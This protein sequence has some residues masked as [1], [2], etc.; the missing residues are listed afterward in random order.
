MNKLLNALQRQQLLWHGSHQPSVTESISTGYQK[1]DHYLGGGFP[2]TGIIE[3]LSHSGIGELK[4][5]LPS[6]IQLDTQRLLIFISPP[7]ILNAP[8]LIQQ[9]IDAG[10]VLIIHP[11]NQKQALWS[12]EQC[13]K[14][15]ACH[16][17]LLWTHQALKIHQIKRL[18]LA[19]R[20][21]NCRQYILRKQRAESLTLPVDLSL[22]LH[23]CSTG[24]KVKINKHKGGW[25]SQIFELNMQ[26]EWPTLTE[27][28]TVNN[29]I[30]LHASS[31]L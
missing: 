29:V 14:S 1:L 8:M 26:D 4:L 3:L 10:S 27:Q 9:H 5:L 2:N 6:L 24:L 11:D 18:Q 28:H 16:S 25:P 7:A 12:A 13:L 15:G 19:C 21:G 22:S 20:K 31:W 30:P 23:S 17:T